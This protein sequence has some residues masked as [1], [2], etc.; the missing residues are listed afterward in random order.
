MCLC[1]PGHSSSA[2]GPGDKGLPEIG[3]DLSSAAGRTMGGPSSRGGCGEGAT[4]SHG[5]GRRPV[6]SRDCC[7]SRSAGAT[8]SKTSST[9]CRRCSR[10]DTP[11]PRRHGSTC[12][13]APACPRRAAGPPTRGPADAPAAGP[14]WSGT[15]APPRRPAAARRS[16]AQARCRRC[17]IRSRLGRPC[18]SQ[19]RSGVCG[20]VR[21]AALS[22]ACIAPQPE[23]P[24]TVIEST[25]S[26]ST[27][28]SI[29]A[30]TESSAALLAGQ[31][32]QI[33]DVAHGEQVARAA[34]GDHA[35]DQPGVGA[36][37]EE[38][39]GPLAL[40]R[41]PGQLLAHQRGRIALERAEP[42]GQLMPAPA[43]A[44][45]RPVRGRAGRRSGG[46]ARASRGGS[47]RATPAARLGDPAARPG[48]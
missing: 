34:G 24:H 44:A 25:C 3:L 18:R 45:A 29:A 8:R 10:A 33:A 46:C 1:V 35:G 43:P 19:R 28:Y 16:C 6:Q 2:R 40:A 31:R 48:R 7:Q 11:G 41:Q 9:S 20:A 39:G 12:R 30:A 36:G 21:A 4:R 5:R 26:T 23:C 32:H 15:A 14:H 38:L 42:A 13:A 47:R 22:S 37:E 17:L 27:A